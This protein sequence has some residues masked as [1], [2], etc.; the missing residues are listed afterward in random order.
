MTPDVFVVDDEPHLRT[1][2]A[3]ALELAGLSAQPLPGADAVLPLLSRGFA[4]IIVSDVRMPGID[5]LALLDHVLAVD[6]DLP[7]ILITGHGDVPMAVAAMARG[8]F[9]FIEKPFAAEAL[10]AAVTTALEKRRLAL[11]VRQLGAP[12]GATD[13]IARSIVGRSAGIVRLR[14][15]IAAFGAADADV[16]ILGETG[17]GK[18]LVARSLHDASRRA[19]KRFVA[20]NCGAL[21]E[22][23]IESELFGHEAGAF[24]GALKARQ[25]KFEYASGGTI[26]LDEIESMP[27]DLQAHLLRVLQ[28]RRIVRLGANA[29]IPVDVRIIAATKEDLRAAADAGRFRLDLYYRLNVL[30]LTIPPLRQRRED[31]PLLFAHFLDEHARRF[32]RQPRQLTAEET[33]RLLRHDWPGNVREIQNVAMRTALGFGI[34][35]GGTV[36]PPPADNDARSL[37]EQVAA[38]EKLIIEQTLERHAGS[39]KATYEALGIGRK[40]LYEKLRRYGIGEPPEDAG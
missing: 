14:G 10:V 12:D 34:E 29:E 39:M 26:L 2:I 36:I 20:I 18:E 35:V 23:V 33:G 13:R 22:S 30:V 27:L 7:V 5:G 17:S 32:E 37:P 3:Q 9:T 1:A 24:T 40:T 25:G 28:E 19:G 11:H 38:L 4:G 6:R 8:A 31:I 16:L 15:E 21:P